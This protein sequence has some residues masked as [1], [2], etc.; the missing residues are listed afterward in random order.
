MAAAIAAEVYKHTPGLTFF[1]RG[2]S[3]SMPSR[4]SE[5]ALQAMSGM[6]LSIKE[7][8]SRQLKQSDIES[9][10]LVVTMTVSQKKYLQSV[11][12]SH[13]RKVLTINEICGRQDTDISD[14]YGSDLYTY[15]KCAED[16]KKCFGRDFE[17]MLN[18][19]ALT[20]E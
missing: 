5:N 16:I 17:K 8:I 20:S 2:I 14:P 18:L 6:N 4:A 11:Y 12:A 19:L 10:D 15:K 1:S 9:A 13:S 7:H 3:V